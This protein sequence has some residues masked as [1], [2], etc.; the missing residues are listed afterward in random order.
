MPAAAT[1]QIPASSTSKTPGQKP[2]PDRKYKC[3]Y[4]ARAFSRSEH[5]SRHERSRKFLRTL[6]FKVVDGGAQRGWWGREAL[7]LPLP[8]THIPT[9]N[10][11]LTYT[12]PYRHQRATFQMSKM[13][14]HLRPSRSAPATRPYRT[15]QRWRGPA[16]QRG[17]EEAGRKTRS[18]D[19]PI[20]GT[21][22]H[23]HSDAGTNRAKQ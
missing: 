8:I 1:A 15:C 6:M 14:K 7:I 5:R 4:C 2:T 13:S 11:V 12:P 22:G 21:A 16:G 10:T 17:Q 9:S 20:Q 18:Q 3:T 23:G 19:T